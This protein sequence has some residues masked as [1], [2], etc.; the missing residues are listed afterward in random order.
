MLNIQEQYRSSKEYILK[1]V[2]K[3]TLNSYYSEY[4]NMYKRYQYISENM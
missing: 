3:E 1:N 4:D 2:D